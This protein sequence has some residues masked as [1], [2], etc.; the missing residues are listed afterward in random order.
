MSRLAAL[1]TDGDI[2]QAV[3]AINE[4]LMELKLLRD[5]ETQEYKEIRIDKKY[6]LDSFRNAIAHE[7]KVLDHD[8][9]KWLKEILGQLLNKIGLLLN[10][11]KVEQLNI[12]NSY[13][14][15]YLKENLN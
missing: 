15:N 3:L 9:E 7:G 8:E 13:I 4:N 2:K 11:N 10:W 14:E 12:L 1:L 5:E 6:T